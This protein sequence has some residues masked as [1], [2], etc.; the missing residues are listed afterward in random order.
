[1]EFGNDKAEV[2][3]DFAKRRLNTFIGGLNVLEALSRR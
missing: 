1:M 2:R 3:V